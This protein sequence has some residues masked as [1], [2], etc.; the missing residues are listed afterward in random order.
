MAQQVFVTYKKELKDIA[1]KIGQQIFSN[2]VIEI[3]DNGLT[4]ADLVMLAN[5]SVTEFFYV[6]NSD[7]EINFTDISFSYKPRNG[8]NI[9]Y[10]SGITTLS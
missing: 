10:T 8:I 6:I 4:S 7:T 3:S 5:K 1:D 2:S 9:Y